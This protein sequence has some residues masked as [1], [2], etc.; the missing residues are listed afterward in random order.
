[1]LKITPTT[2]DHFPAYSLVEDFGRT[3]DQLASVLC[4]PRRADDGGHG[5]A[6]EGGD[7]GQLAK[8]GAGPVCDSNHV[9]ADPRSFRSSFRAQADNRKGRTNR[10]RL[11]TA[12]LLNGGNGRETCSSG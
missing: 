5:L 2:S 4:L 12:I 10:T 9:V 3:G 7:L 1:M 6:I 11:A 8:G